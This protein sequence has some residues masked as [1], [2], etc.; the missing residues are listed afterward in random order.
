[1]Q[2]RVVNRYKENFT[3]YIGRSKST[4]HFGNPISHN[5]S[6]I[7]KIKTD[8]R[9]QSIEGFYAWLM[10]TDFQHIE[11][12]RREWILNNIESLRGEVLGCSCKPKSCH[13][14]IYRVLL[15][16]LTLD[17]VIGTKKAAI[18]AAQFDLF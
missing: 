6:K 8:S 14:D 7:A 4:M 12:K 1:M 17:E 3:V 16:E 9:D 2:T 5:D 11:P 18:E 13:G 10:G 15:G